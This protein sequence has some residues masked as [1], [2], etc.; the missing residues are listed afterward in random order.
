MSTVAAPHVTNKQLK[1]EFER[2]FHEYSS[3]IYRTAY[4]VTGNAEDAEDVLQ[5]IFLRLMRRELPPN[6]KNNPKAYLYRAA[7][8]VSLSTLRS[9]RQ[10]ELVGDLEGFESSV[11]AAQSR[12]AS[13]VR[14]R[15]LATLETMAESNPAGV[16][17]L[18]LRY[19]HNYP[20]AD[21]G[22]MFGQSRGVVAV[23]L[24]RAR[25]RLKK[26]MRESGERR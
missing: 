23:R 11:H 20:D 8:N 15:L 2:I 3:F 4:G 10:R 26:L 12:S 19:V 7:V 9:R 1:Q 16:E 5:T 14:E 21:I 25:N 17:L 18:I 13:Q 22:K 6:L 24:F